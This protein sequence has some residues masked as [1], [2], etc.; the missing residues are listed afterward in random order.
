MNPTMDTTA[1]ASPAWPTLLGVHAVVVLAL[2]VTVLQNVDDTAVDIPPIE[3]R[4][5]A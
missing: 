4:L 3:K 5:L 2:G 1:Q